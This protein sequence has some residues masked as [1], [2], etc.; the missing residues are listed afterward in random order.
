MPFVIDII[1]IDKASTIFFDFEVSGVIRLWR[2][3]ESCDHLPD[4]RP[5]NI[6]RSKADDNMNILLCTDKSS[7]NPAN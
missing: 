7:E 2:V 3:C 6:S 4:P 1:N 5:A